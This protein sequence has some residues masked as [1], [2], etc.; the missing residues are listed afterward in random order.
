MSQASSPLTGQGY[1]MG[2]SSVVQLSSKQW[3]ALKREGIENVGDL[4]E[5]KDDDINNVIFN[6]IRP[7][8]S[9]HPTIPTHTGSAE[10]AVDNAAVLPVPFQAVVTQRDSVDASTEKQPHLVC[11]LLLVKKMKLAVDIFCYYTSIE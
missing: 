8:D 5:F 1:F 4:V 9:W 6:L 3:V 7:Q 2:N 11:S 10:I